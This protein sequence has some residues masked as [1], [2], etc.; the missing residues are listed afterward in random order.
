MGSESIIPQKNF[1]LAFSFEKMFLKLSLSLR[2]L[3]VGIIAPLQKLLWKDILR[4][5][6]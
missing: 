4:I 3:K 1:T 6:M 5:F 2:S